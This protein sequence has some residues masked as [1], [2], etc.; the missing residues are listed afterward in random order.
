M[1]DLVSTDDE[2][3][4]D[5]IRAVLPQVQEARE[6]ELSPQEQVGWREK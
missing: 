1:R 4:D 2:L 5:R 6:E 3:K